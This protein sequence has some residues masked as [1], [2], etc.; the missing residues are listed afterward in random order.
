MSSIRWSAALF[1]ALACLPACRSD[2][3]GTGPPVPASSDPEGKDLVEGAIVAAFEK[4][5]G[6][7]L[8]KVKKVNF[9]PP[10]MTDELVMVAF[11]EKANDF[12]HASDLWRRR[13][14]TVAVAD[15]R[16]QRHMFRTRDYRVLANEPV[17]ASDQKLKA[18]DKFE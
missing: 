11:N 7:R 2:G 6:V 17:T 8:Y 5:G 10:P 16:V 1:V 15:V 4:D 3:S 18:D 9:F 13:K 14:F 12:Q